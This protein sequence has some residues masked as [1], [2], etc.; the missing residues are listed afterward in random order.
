[1]GEAGDDSGGTDSLRY[2]L[3]RELPG[4]M[5]PAAFVFVTE[6]PLTA[7]GKLDLRALPAP[8]SDRPSLSTA[9]VAPRGTT[10]ET[11]ASVWRDVLGLSEL[12]V[13]DNF[14]DLGG[15]SLLLARTRTRLTAATG[16]D[17]P[18][19]ELFRHPTVALLARF[20]SGGQLAGQPRRD[21][22]ERHSEDRRRALAE[23]ARRT[24]DRQSRMGSA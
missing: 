22:R 10:E 14:F 20:L 11:V 7:S 8:G 6:L 2:R 24:Q 4:Y 21:G 9:C 3:G 18:T 1:V 15:N 17:V 23:R 19:V 16:V 13:H 5:V 12:G